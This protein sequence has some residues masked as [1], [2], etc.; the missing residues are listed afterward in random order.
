MNI[1]QGVLITTLYLVTHSNRTFSHSPVFLE[2][3]CRSVHA[4][5]YICMTVCRRV[6]VMPNF[7]SLLKTP[8]QNWCGYEMK[9]SLTDIFNK[10]ISVLASFR[11]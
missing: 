5:Y 2:R 7:D 10:Y 9:S 11:P 6:N 8:H 4:F 3:L 1:Q